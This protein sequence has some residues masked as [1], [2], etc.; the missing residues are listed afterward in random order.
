MFPALRILLVT[1]LITA[2]VAMETPADPDGIAFFEAKIRPV[3]ADKC[4]ECHSAAK[5]VKANLHLDSRAGM[6]A[7]GESGPSVVPGRPEKSLLIKAISYHDEDLEMPPKERLSDAVVADFVAWVKR[8]AP[9]PRVD[10]KTPIGP[11]YAKAKEHW[12]YRPLQRPPVPVPRDTTWPR[13]PVDHFIRAA[14]EQAMVAPAAP[15]DRRAIIRRLTLDLTG[16][17][18]TPEE[19]DAFIAD[20][21]PDALER[22]VDRLL[23][24]PQFGVR[25]ARHWLDLARFAESHGYEQDYDRPFA[26]HYRDFVVDAFNQDLPWTTFTTWQLAGDEVAPENDM[27]LKA[28]G[29]LAAGVWPTQITKNE[30]AKARYDALDDML[31]T[32]FTA[33]LGTT[34]AC[35][36]CHDH[37]LDPI[38]SRDYYQLLATF[39]TTVRTEIERDATSADFPQRLAAFTAAHEPLV[40]A[41]EAYERDQL[42]AKFAVAE[43]AIDA[44][45]L[46]WIV[47]VPTVRKSS[48]GATITPQDD[49]SLL[50]TGKNPDHETL[51]FTVVSDLVGITGLRLEALAHP[52]LKK[53]GPGR[54]DNGNFCLSDLS[55]TAAPRSGGEPVTV[56]LIQAASTFDQQGLGVALAIDAD[57][58]SGWAV[59]PQF[60]KDHAGVFTF[61]EPVAFPGG[62][63]L[64]ITLR[65]A[66]NLRH[67]M[68]R[69]RL[70]L[71]TGP[72][73]L[74]GGSLTAEVASALRIPAAERTAAQRTTLLH[75]W[76]GT[77]PGWRALKEQVDAHQRQQPQ[78]EQTKVLIASE[79]L[80]AVRLHT[81]GA[82]FF[83]ETHFLRRGDPDQRMEV[84]SQGFWSLFAVDGPSRWQQAPPS[85]ARTSHRR[86]ALARWM[87]DV[88]HGAG[89][90]LARVAVNRVWQHLFAKG[91]VATPSD[92]GYS[93]ERPTHPDLL[94]WLA[95]EF[96]AGGWRVK[97]LIRSL[98]LSA[99]YAQS[100]MANAEALANDPQNRLLTRHRRHRLEAEAVRDTLLAISGLLD[101]RL[102]GAGTR[103]ESSRRR[104]LYFTIKRS[105][106]IPFLVAFDFPEPLQGVAE[107]PA[108]IVAPQALALLNNPQARVWAE[109][110]AKRLSGVG[111]D[112]ATVTAAWRIALGRDPGTDES[113]D[114]ATFLSRQT[115]ARGDR[116]AALA[117][118][119]Q[120]VMCLNEVIHVR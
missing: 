21:A 111:D 25:W 64:T 49:G 108:T 110:F 28:T 102:G 41:L 20:G 14:Q 73:T 48:G 44:A 79:G 60:G 72:V 94:D 119:A 5:K 104:S 56:K 16:L 114:A 36:R 92:F 103:D 117:D 78:R 3:L 54:A 68:G 80:P 97:P 39:T 62:A 118:F 67:G 55:V 38:R 37:K 33:M 17:P 106:L 93:G 70:S 15:A 112:V 71:T 9:D 107:R 99:T 75:W 77:D 18:P 46:R 115:E 86:A 98:V 40:A 2:A 76:R 120:V 26:W 74:D 13:T 100:G 42:P 51:T 12:A 31:G 90:L 61:A 1:G 7:G 105:A 24:S 96:I 91:L 65:F 47:A 50:V 52:S 109:G 11:D 30:V 101:P 58:T 95:S 34:V 87:T 81:Q 57:G 45:A 32:T 88:D 59:D 89:H 19:V 23:A 85:G 69:P 10:S 84:V 4:Y 43:P 22:V 113:R 116:A 66:N 83:P 27:A 82:D 6:L 29:F 63:I 35:A 53:G 8:G